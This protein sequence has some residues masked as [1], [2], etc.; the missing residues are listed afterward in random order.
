VTQL[1]LFPRPTS[2]ERARQHD[3]LHGKI[4]SLHTW[5]SKG[6]PSVPGRHLLVLGALP[7]PPA[8]MTGAEL[9]AFCLKFAEAI[10]AQRDA[11]LDAAADPS[12][13]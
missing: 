3:L 5:P 9:D 1:R 11:R 8:E 10:N 12:A 2:D 4:E 13:T 7:K 6:E